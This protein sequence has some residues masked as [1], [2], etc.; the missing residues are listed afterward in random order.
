[1]AILSSVCAAALSGCCL[2][3]EDLSGCASA[4]GVDYEL[5]LITN[6]QTELHTVLSMDTEIKTSVAIE[7]YMSQIFTDYAHDVDLSFYDV[8]GDMPILEHMSE[9][10][11][12]NQTSYSLYIPVH[13]YIHTCVAN[14]SEAGALTLEGVDHCKSAKLVQHET[15]GYVEP[16]GRG[17][18]TA[19]SKMDVKS[20]IDQ[21]F[22][23]SLYMVNAATCLVMDTS[24][25]PGIK[26]IRVEVD[27]FA[28]GFQIADSTYTFD[29]NP[30]IKAVPVPVEG[31]SEVCYTA[32]HF[33]SRDELPESKVIINVDDSDMKDMGEP[34]WR[35]IVYVTLRDDTIT[36][37]EL[38]VYKSLPA[39]HIKI[40]KADVYENGGV[41]VNDPMVG[42]SV[43]L[44]WNEGGSHTVDL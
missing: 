7:A 43:T 15:D 20:G 33:P 44:N 19:R 24:S 3:D 23:V 12:A 10:M 35:W 26:D 13:D 32:V 17:V 6:L 38:Y 9:I 42:A 31:S 14:I 18:F 28:D 22:N 39:G 29:S 11:D 27:G 5:R 4:S 36:K 37:T 21:T 34:V 30:R 40:A 25:A 8:D 41:S 2:I 1:M 16:H